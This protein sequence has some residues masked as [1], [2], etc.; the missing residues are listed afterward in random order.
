MNPSWPDSQGR[1]QVPQYL[2]AYAGLEKNVVISGH[3][4]TA[5]IWDEGEWNKRMT[6]LTPQNVAAVMAALG[7]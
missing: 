1:I 3:I 4:D 2:R 7:I 5:K 6:E